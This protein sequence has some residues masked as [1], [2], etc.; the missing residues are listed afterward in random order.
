[1]KKTLIICIFVFV[2]VL[3]S[4]F[5]FNYMQILKMKEE[6]KINN[7][8]QLK[9]NEYNKCYKYSN[10]IYVNIGTLDTNTGTISGDMTLNSDSYNNLQKLKNCLEEAYNK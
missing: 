10:K 5:L 4:I 2:T 1:M 6:N 8:L 7:S 9:I 3:S